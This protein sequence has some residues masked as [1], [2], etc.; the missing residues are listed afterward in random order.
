MFSKHLY[1]IKIITVEKLG[2]VNVWPFQL[3]I[4]LMMITIA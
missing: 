1:T 3:D 2:P 4:C